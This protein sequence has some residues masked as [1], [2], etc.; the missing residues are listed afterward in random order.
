M[1]SKRNRLQDGG[2]EVLEQIKEFRELTTDTEGVG[3]IKMIGTGNRIFGGFLI[4]ASLHN[5]GY[6][7]E[8]SAWFKP[9]HFYCPRERARC[10]KH[11]SGRSSSALEATD[12]QT[13]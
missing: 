3:G 8:E 5:I 11:A 12:I 2:F 7:E 1:V 13:S 10:A 6:T 4:P 9:Y